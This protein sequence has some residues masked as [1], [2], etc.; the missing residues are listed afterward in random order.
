MSR[1]IKN[2]EAL[3]EI[4]QDF[5]YDS[6]DC[7]WRLTPIRPAPALS[8]QQSWQ[9]DSALLQLPS[10]T[11]ALIDPPSGSTL[12]TAAVLLRLGGFL[13]SGSLCHEFVLMH[14]SATTKKKKE[15]KFVFKYVNK[16]FKSVK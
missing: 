4:M 3:S 7:D 8:R 13:H 14:G 2:K 12:L 15:K 10:S 9:V 16:M 6:E 5:K 1:I 11:P